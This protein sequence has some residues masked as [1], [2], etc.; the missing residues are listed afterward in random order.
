MGLKFLT[1]L[2]FSTLG[3]AKGGGTGGLRDFKLPP[4]PTKVVIFEQKES[5]CKDLSIS[6]AQKLHQVNSDSDD[7]L[8]A[9][10]RTRM[11]E[12]KQYFIGTEAKLKVEI[13]YVFLKDETPKHL[14]QVEAEQTDTDCFIRSVKYISG[15]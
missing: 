8:E 3:F 15:K 10:Y 13:W 12:G 11:L 1:F 9:S 14:Y 6:A 7:L 5:Q 2:L 4:Q